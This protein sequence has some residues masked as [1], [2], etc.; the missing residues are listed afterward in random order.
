MPIA[1]TDN[2]L[3]GADNMQVAGLVLVMLLFFGGFLLAQAIFYHHTGRTFW[4]A[5]VPAGLRYTLLPKDNVHLD[6]FA[7][8]EEYAALMFM[9]SLLILP[10]IAL[11]TMGFLSLF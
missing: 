7:V 1:L 10:L 5:M 3:S 6:S 9:A 11:S 2:I 4:R 8:M